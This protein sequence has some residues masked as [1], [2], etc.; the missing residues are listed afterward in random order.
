MPLAGAV[1]GLLVSARYATAAT[2]LGAAVLIGMGFHTIREASDVTEEAKQLDFTS[3]RSV[4]LAGFAISTDELVFGF[5]L[6]LTGLPL[7]PV[8]V[9]IAGQAFIVG[10]VGVMFG[11]WMSSR[12][13]QIAET[14]AGIAFIGLGAYLIFEH[15]VTSP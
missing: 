5:P 9:L 4:A 3:L 7:A 12:V 14:A 1:L 11:R 2:Y 13:S 8:L 10:Y 15:V 6:G